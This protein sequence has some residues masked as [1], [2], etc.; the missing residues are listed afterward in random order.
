MVLV[1]KSCSLTLHLLLVLKFEV[2]IGQRKLAIPLRVYHTSE[3]R[4]RSFP[5]L[6]YSDD[7][8]LCNVNTALRLHM[9][10]VMGP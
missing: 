4:H 10:I 6:S 2:L 5:L 1:D 7:V 8:L 9:Q 3:L